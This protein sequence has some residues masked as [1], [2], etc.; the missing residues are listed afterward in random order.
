LHASCDVWLRRNGRHSGKSPIR[1]GIAVIHMRG[2]ALLLVATLATSAAPA[3]RI[4][5][6][7][8]THKAGI[9]LLSIF[10]WRAPSA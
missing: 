5:P 9:S 10:E 4:L 2:E 7:V 1:G 6:L 8:T 3:L